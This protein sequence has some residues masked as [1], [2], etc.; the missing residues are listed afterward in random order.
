MKSFVN[1]FIYFR[2]YRNYSYTKED[3]V[4]N[5]RNI[6]YMQYCHQNDQTMILF[7]YNCNYDKMIEMKGNKIPELLDVLNRNYT[8]G[9]II[10]GDKIS[11]LL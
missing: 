1:K 10:E 6:G 11:E 8:K 7:T 3:I 2:Y 5:A 4:F 9:C